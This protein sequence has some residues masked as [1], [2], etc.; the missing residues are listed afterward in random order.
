MRHPPQALIALGD[1]LSR[2]AR[3]SLGTEVL[4]VEG[5]EHGA[6][7]HRAE[8][9]AVVRLEGATAVE[10]A[11]EPPRE[12]VA[13]AG[14]VAHVLEEEARQGV[15]ALSREQCGSVLTPL[16][17]H[18]PRPHV[19]HRPR[20]PGQA[21]LRGQHPQLGVVQHQAVDLG[22]RGDQRVAGGVDPEVHRVEGR[23]PRGLALAS[24]APLEVGLD[25][26]QKQHVRLPRR[27]G[28]LRL[29][30]G[31]D[32]EPGVIRVGNVEVGVVV[33]SPE[34][35]LAALDALDVRDVDPS[36]AEQLDVLLAEVVAHRPDHVGLG[37]E[38][39]GEREVNRRA[40]QH[41]FALAERRTHGVERD[42]AD[43]RQRHGRAS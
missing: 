40:P 35:G 17:D 37:E 12:A 38:A 9:D 11:E 23:Q 28:Q 39:G 10:V 13:G 16:G 20:G 14:R 43:H 8:E 3:H 33:P 42:R 27:L 30:I 1:L 32:A 2:E 22:D 18:D 15:D 19:H 6:I 41:A 36:R 34:E 31:E 24:N 25:V 4:D 26:S 5:G 7:G 21:R 29:E